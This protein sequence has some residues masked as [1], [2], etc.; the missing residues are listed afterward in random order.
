MR[1]VPIDSVIITENDTASTT[2][3]WIRE[4]K[5]TL[6]T[7][8]SQAKTELLPT[9]KPSMRLSAHLKPGFVRAHSFC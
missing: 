6:L 5:K 2:D 4:R 9:Q 1:I 7:P 8:K 3:V